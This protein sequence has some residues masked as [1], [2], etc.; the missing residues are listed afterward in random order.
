[1]WY[2]LN[3]KSLYTYVMLLQNGTKL[4]TQ[5]SKLSSLLLRDLVLRVIFLNHSGWLKVNKTNHLG[6]KKSLPSCDT[7]LVTC[8]W[9]VTFSPPFPQDILCQGA[10]FKTDLV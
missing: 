4:C 2:T 7:Y 5:V 3:N 10:G 1:M 8:N 6:Y 9:L